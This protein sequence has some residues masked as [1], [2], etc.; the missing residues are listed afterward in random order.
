MNEQYVT[1][2]TCADKMAAVEVAIG[3]IETNITNIRGEIGAIIID[4]N[5][6]CGKTDSNILDYKALVESKL[7]DIEDYLNNVVKK[8]LDTIVTQSEFLEELSSTEKR[9]ASDINDYIA[10]CDEKYTAINKKLVNFE[11]LILELQKDIEEIARIEDIEEIY[12]RFNNK[13]KDYAAE[14]EMSISNL[15][16]DLELADSEL[17]EKFEFLFNGLEA[18]QKEDKKELLSKHYDVIAY[19]ES[20][21]IAGIDEN[22]KKL[23]KRV[24]EFELNWTVIQK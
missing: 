6:R 24:E 14:L 5:N 13:F 17:D 11:L 15:K 4:V 19:L 8:T 20:I 23:E 3:N 10:Q 22:F 1:R 21:D 18:K 16:K 2:I 7:K 12:Q 9:F